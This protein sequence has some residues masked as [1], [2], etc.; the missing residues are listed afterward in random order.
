MKD[1]PVGEMLPE[2]DKASSFGPSIERTSRNDETNFYF[3]NNQKG[4]I[5]NSKTQCISETVMFVADNIQEV[6]RLSLDFVVIIIKTLGGNSKT[7]RRIQNKPANK[8]YFM[9]I[10]I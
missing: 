5:C 6:L 10:S 7:E 9:N 2:F 1:H 4:L 3:S 8:E